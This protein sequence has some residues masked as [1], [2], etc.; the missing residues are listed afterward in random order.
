MY[1]SQ[2]LLQAF[3]MHWLITFSHIPVRTVI[4]P[5]LSSGS[6][7][8]PWSGLH[9]WQKWQGWNLNPGSMAQQNL[10]WP[11]SCD[12]HKKMDPFVYLSR[13]AHV[14]VLHP[15]RIREMFYF[16]VFLVSVLNFKNW[17][18]IF[19]TTLSEYWL[20]IYSNQE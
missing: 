14:I 16:Y 2:A 6:D 15:V 20:L 12:I 4:C 18:A 11:L 10:C 17:K 13:F 9:D 8:T 1:S 7:S 3:Y 19:M 5:A